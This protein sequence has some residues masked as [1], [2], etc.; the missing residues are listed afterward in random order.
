MRFLIGCVL[1]GCVGAGV[2]VT[3]LDDLPRG[4]NGPRGSLVAQE[5]DE[6]G[7]PPALPAPGDSTGTRPG[8]RPRP[9]AGRA[10]YE[11]ADFGDAPADGSPAPGVPASSAATLYGPD[12]MTAEEAVNVAVYDRCNRAVVNIVTRSVSRDRFLFAEYETEGNGSGAVID[13]RGHV[14]TNYHVVEEAERIEVTLYDGETYDAVPVGADPVNDIAVVRIDA[15]ADALFPV[16][17][18]DSSDLQVGRRVYAIGNPFGLER[19][20]TTGIISS[21]NR[22]LRIRGDRTVRQIIQ[23]DA[24]V[25]PGNSGGPLLDSHGRL[26]G[27]NTA[28]ASRNGQSAGVGFAIPV[29]LAGRVVPQ[30][31]RYGRVI[32]PEIGIAKVFETPKGLLVA[33]LTPDGPAERAGVRGPRV[34]RTRRGPF[35]VE[36]LD[37]S[38][39]DL[40]VAVDGT[41]V[42]TN[43]DFLSDIEQRKPGERVRLT[44]LRDGRRVELD[45][46]LAG[47]AAD[48][49]P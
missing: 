30:I 6:F 49:V 11:P 17:F 8:T 32:R 22:S 2:A 38:A 19:T 10:T 42:E 27:I 35:V 7:R 41:A 31:V 15:P 45:V 14:L 48:A 33:K 21:L 12:G 40:I 23:I 5:G 9:N 4:S 34:E 46:T 36:K 25:N 24:A 37:N 43:D 16:E 47:P 18:G 26:I 20:M 13:R 39:A 29:N 28:I 44:V 1:S 3:L